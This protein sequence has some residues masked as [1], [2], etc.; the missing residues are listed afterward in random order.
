M[1][2]FG[3]LWES[4]DER[5]LMASVIQAGAVWYDLDARAYRRE[6]GGQ[7]VL[8]AWLPGA[9]VTGDPVTLDA[10]G[11]LAADRPTRIASI[12]DLEQWGWQSIQ[13][14]LVLIP[15]VAAGEVNRFLAIAGPLDAEAEAMLVE[16]CRAAGATIEQLADRRGK[17]IRARL[18]R[19]ASQAAGSFAT[20]VRAMASEFM[21][22]VGAGAV[23]VTVERPGQQAMTVCSA[24]E[25]DW[26]DCPL[27]GI[28]SGEAQVSGGRMALCFAFGGGASGVV[29]LLAPADAPFR[30]EQARAARE[31]LDVLATWLSGTSIGFAGAAGER[32]AA[33]ASRPF[34]ESMRDELARAKRLSLSGGVLL[35]SVPRAKDHDP[36]V[37]AR[38]IRAVR[39]ELRTADLLG[40]L[41]GG[42]VAAVLVRTDPDGVARAADRV[43]AKLDAMAR[44]HELPPIA[45]G[46]A[47]YPAGQE[48]SPASLLERA[49]QQAGLTFS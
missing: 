2:F 15:V 18:A 39:S 22:A 8:E 9:D 3:H 48:A 38:L 41:S 21:D 45:V 12:G 35:A 6:F 5:E 19:R 42:D 10:D 47:L 13:G 1:H 17:E 49:R 44:A 30:A 36:Q 25:A 24:G 11:L 26:E 33:P 43:R 46:H 37:T 28:S 40:Q 16:V 14:E 32:Q 31:G 27:P 7:F 34:D 20:A 23:R 29:E 4:A